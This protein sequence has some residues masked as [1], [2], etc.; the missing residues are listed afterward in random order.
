MELDVQTTRT[1]GTG[2][3]TLRGDVDVFSAPLLRQTIVD[4][5]NDGA[6]RLLIDLEAV[7][8]LDATGVGVLQE[9]A[10]RAGGQGGSL[11]VVGGPGVI[12]EIIEAGGAGT[13]IRLHSSRDEAL[14]DSD[15]EG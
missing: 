15:L 8:H 13:Q 10:K 14:R 7:E 5:V 1:D 4:L 12:R 6:V 9:G 3:I 11:G 2:I